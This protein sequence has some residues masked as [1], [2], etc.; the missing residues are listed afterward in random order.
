MGI[1]RTE[2]TMGVFKEIGVRKFLKTKMRRI[3]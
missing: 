1:F 3:T 2:G